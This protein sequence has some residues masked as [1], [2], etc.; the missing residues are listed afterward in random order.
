M[1]KP[2]ED[3]FG[4]QPGVEEISLSGG[5]IGAKAEGVGKEAV[6]ELI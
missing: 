3:I 4:H 6:I 5:G 1:R 2:T